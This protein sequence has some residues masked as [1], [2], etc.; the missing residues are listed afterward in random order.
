MEL[1]FVA[2]TNHEG[3]GTWCVFSYGAARG[4]GIL[5]PVYYELV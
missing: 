1:N 4:K 5:V 3:D 2:G